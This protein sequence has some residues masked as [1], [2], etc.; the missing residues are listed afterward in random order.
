MQDLKRYLRGDGE[1]EGVI[2]EL[3]KD[4]SGRLRLGKTMKKRTEKLADKLRCKITGKARLPEDM[5]EMIRELFAMLLYTFL[6][7]T[8]LVDS[9]EFES[10]DGLIRG[11][12][13]GS[14][15]PGDYASTL[16]SRIKVRICAPTHG[17]RKSAKPSKF[18]CSFI[19]NSLED[20]R[21]VSEYNADFNGVSDR[22]TEP[23]TSSVVSCASNSL[24]LL[25]IEHDAVMALLLKCRRDRD[26]RERHPER[27]EFERVKSF[28]HDPT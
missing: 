7:Y 25:H 3:N 27:S 14:T 22:P 24:V 2:A 6:G 8:D 11:R 23:T 16:L 19:V 4:L 26:H 1:H 28:Q 9:M 13:I 17:W 21:M 18:Q 20:R 15:T 10:I 5:G 12:D